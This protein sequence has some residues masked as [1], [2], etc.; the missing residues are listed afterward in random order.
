M[1]ALLEIYSDYL[2][3]L[4]RQAWHDLERF[5]AEEVCYN[6]QETG[7]AGYRS[8]LEQ[9]YKNIP[10]LHYQAEIVLADTSFIACRLFFDCSPQ[11]TFLGLPLNGRRIRFSEHAFYQFQDFKIA[12][13]WSV[14]DKAK[15]E[16][17]LD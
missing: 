7:L 11:D 13:V 17:Q 6:D 15:I 1:N 10:D 14:I 3:C 5:V 2:T 4:N 8:M 12:H 9:D 16:Q